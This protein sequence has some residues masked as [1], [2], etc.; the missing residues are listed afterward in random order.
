MSTNDSGVIIGLTGGIATGKST[1]SRYFQ[2]E[3]VPVIDA[4]ELARKIVAPG[5]PALKEIVDTFGDQVLRDDGTLDRSRLGDKIFRNEAARKSLEAVTHP[6]IAQAMVDEARKKFEAGH[7]WVLYDAAL[8]VETGTHQ[9]LDALIVVDCSA[10]T[11]RRRLQQRDEL[12]REQAQ[13][14]I[15]SQMPLSEKRQAADFIID[16]DGSRDETRAQV[17][18]LKQRIDELIKS[19]GTATP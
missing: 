5:Q 1:V 14:R 11:Q 17:Q 9:W 8:L 6:R 16:N 15:E 7:D 3:G 2:D 12:N 4:D 18:Q 19:H 10:R 13:Q